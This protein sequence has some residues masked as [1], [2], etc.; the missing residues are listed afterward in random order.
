MNDWISVEDKLPEPD[1]L[2]VAAKLYDWWD[3]D[4]AVCNFYHGKFC[5]NCDGLEA[6]NWDGGACITLDFIPTHW[7]PLP[8]LK[9]KETSE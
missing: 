8:T 9:P 6:S 2:V 5:L 3:P 7:Y 4:A 1:T